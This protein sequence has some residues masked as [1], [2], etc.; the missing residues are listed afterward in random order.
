MCEIENK[1]VNIFDIDM[2]PIRK[3]TIP[4]SSFIAAKKKTQLVMEVRRQEAEST[5]VAYH[6]IVERIIW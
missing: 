2:Q 5:E 3:L 4:K 1:R 6:S